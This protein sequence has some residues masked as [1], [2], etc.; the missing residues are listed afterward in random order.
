MKKLVFQK[1]HFK[2]NK[3]ITLIALIITIIVLLI[4]AGVSI[5]TLTGENG[6]VKEATTA[7]QASEVKSWEERIDTAILEAEKNHLNPSI[8]DVIE[9]LEKAGI[10]EDA[11]KVDKETGA[12]ITKEPSYEIG[13]K[14]DDYLSDDDVEIG[15]NPSIPSE[16]EDNVNNEDDV[17][18]EDNYI[19]LKPGEEAS[20]TQKDNYTDL[21]GDKA[22]IPEGFKVSDKDGEKTVD[23]GLVVINT[24]DSSEFVW[25]PVPIAISPTEA[26][27]NTNKAMAV[28]I[29]NNYRSLLYE[30]T[31]TS[32][33]VQEG[34]TTAQ[35]KMPNF[36]SSDREPDTISDYDNDMDYL[37]FINEKFGETK[38]TNSTEL[39]TYLQTEYDNMIESVN[40]YGG[41][42]IGRYETSIDGEGAKSVKGVYSVSAADSN[43]QAWF[44][45]FGA[46][47]KYETNSVKGQM[48]TGSQWDAML[49]WMQKGGQINVAINGAPIEGATFNASFITGSEEKDKLKNIYDIIGCRMEFTTEA[50]ASYIRFVRGSSRA[51]FYKISGRTTPLASSTDNYKGSRLTLYVK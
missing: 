11:S 36:V 29:G 18:D 5:A 10:I 13:G 49:N 4:L 41:F 51:G 45:L 50:S 46:Q 37:K 42:Y 24:D 14:L 34:C 9:E 25:I 6:V 16:S 22:T 26:E 40:K 8:D 2:T 44:G 39:K 19:G 21:S 48:V 20:S 38:F 35:E 17:N 28:K 47:H 15:E 33:T 23:D 12:I 1:K 7:K 3:G 43:G 32:S 30:F 31:E 27:G